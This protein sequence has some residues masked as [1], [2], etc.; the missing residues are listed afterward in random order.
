MKGDWIYCPLSRHFT[1][2]LSHDTHR[3]QW[4]SMALDMIP[5][6]PKWCSLCYWVYRKNKCNGRGNCYFWKGGGGG[7]ADRTCFSGDVWV[8]SANNAIRLQD[9]NLNMF[10]SIKM[11]LF[12]CRSYTAAIW[13]FCLCV[14]LWVVARQNDTNQHICHVLAAIDAQLYLCMYRTHLVYILFHVLSTC[15]MYVLYMC[16]S[17]CQL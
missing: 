1:H 9:L 4:Q 11:S 3:F 10:N 5:L 17:Q 14:W 2:C 7:G 8:V 6:P 13:S 15:S 12:N 16:L